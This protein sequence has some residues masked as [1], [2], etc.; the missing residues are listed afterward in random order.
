MF[1]TQYAFSIS[2]FLLC[3]NI[4]GNIYHGFFLFLFAAGG[5]RF[6]HFKIV[7]VKYVFA[8]FFASDFKDVSNYELPFFVFG[9]KTAALFYLYC[10]FHT[11]EVLKGGGNR[12]R[13]RP[14]PLHYSYRKAKIVTPLSY[15]TGGGTVI[16][17][18]Y[19]NSRLSPRS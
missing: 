5:Q 2:L 10:F 3:Q 9:R 8:S 16:S 6:G 1:Q 19:E 15:H 17:G 18:S 4:L 11:R 12:K 14:D 13:L 7:G